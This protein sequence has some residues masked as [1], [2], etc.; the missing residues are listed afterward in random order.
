VNADLV[1]RAYEA[2]AVRDLEAMGAVIH[3]E[4]EFHAPTARLAGAE[5]PYRGREGMAEYF[6]D[7]AR[8]WEVVRLEPRDYHELGDRV[9]VLGRVYAWGGGRVIDAPAAWVWRLRDGLVDYCRVYESTR[10]AL[11]AVGLDA[12]PSDD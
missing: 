6:Q 9:L 12:I 11:D 7:A 10:A 4:L 3:P 1:A 5:G 2:F 8:V